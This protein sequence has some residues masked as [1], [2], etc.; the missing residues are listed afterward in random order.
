M[1]V[2]GQVMGERFHR[3]T[4]AL[5]N[6][7]MWLWW[8]PA[9]KSSVSL[10]SLSTISEIWRARQAAFPASCVILRTECSVRKDPLSWWRNPLSSEDRVA[11]LSCWGQWRELC[12][13][14]PEYSDHSFTMEALAC[15][16]RV[17]SCRHHGGHPPIW[18]FISSGN[19]GRKHWGWWKSSQ[20][21]DMIKSIIHRNS[22]PCGTD[23]AGQMSSGSRPAPPG[24]TAG[25]HTGES[26]PRRATP[27]GD[28]VRD[29]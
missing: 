25:G 4:D 15:F 20:K 2:C 5:H 1:R 27:C 8:W 14:C 26:G 12:H 28:N 29:G 6:L 19:G 24:H 16:P 10:A 17:Q 13:L 11:L 18:D 7:L 23:P 21:T 22:R 3:R 9:Y